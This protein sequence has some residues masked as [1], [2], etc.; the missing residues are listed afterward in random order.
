MGEIKLD[1]SL[2]ENFYWLNE[3]QKYYLNNTLVIKTAPE[4]DFWQK[5]HYGFR[6]DNGHALLT[7]LKND[8]SF[9]VKVKLNFKN[10]YDQC[11]IMLRLDSKN[12]IKISAEYEN[13][14]I[15][16]LGSV[17]TNLGYSDWATE[18]ISSSI[19]ELW[20]RVNKSGSDF[21]IENSFDGHKW[22]QMRITHLIK[23]FKIVSHPSVVL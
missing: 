20:Y 21:F 16:R 11:G 22:S 23:D 8:F 7:D 6:K 17:V 18:D 3:P 15:T 19:N 1:K 5:T 2:L 10:K 4:T 13:Q 9:K 12:W 14:T